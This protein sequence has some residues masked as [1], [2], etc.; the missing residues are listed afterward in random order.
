VEQ[1]EANKVRFHEVDQD[2]KPADPEAAL[3]D[4]DAD[5]TKGAGRAGF[6]PFIAILWILAAILVVGGIW[7]FTNAFSTGPT[8]SSGSVPLGFVL[9][10]FAPWAVLSGTLAVMTLLFWHAAQ[11]QR[12]RA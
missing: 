12:R 3:G 6:N 4:H 10:N 8:S 7:V 5:G 2:G 11:W 1:A 9:I